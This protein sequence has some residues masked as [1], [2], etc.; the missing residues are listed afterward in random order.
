[1]ARMMRVRR[2]WWEL[3]IVVTYRFVSGRPLDGERRTD[4]TW[5]WA[6]TK[7]TRSGVERFSAWSALPGW[8]RQ[9][10][11]LVFV[12]PPIAAGV[13]WVARL[14]HLPAWVTL[15]ARGA[16]LVVLA[17]ALAVVGLAAWRAVGRLLEWRHRREWVLPLHKALIKP[18]GLGVR[19]RPESYLTVP[20]DFRSNP[21]A[22]IRVELPDT[23]ASEPGV[24]A[25]LAEVITS[26]LPL[27]S[28]DVM[29]RVAGK[30][31]HVIVRQAPAPP[32][33]VDYATAIPHMRTAPDSAPFLGLGIRSKPIAV[34]L[35]AESPHVLISASSG[36]GKSVLARLIMCQV[37]ANGGRV[38]VLDVKRVSHAWA[39]G[40][41]GVAYCRSPEEIHAAL[42][43]V[44]AEGDRRYDL[45]DAEGE[46]ACDRLPRILVVA[47]EMNATI[48]R[49]NRYWGKIR[50]AD[51]P[52]ISPAVEALGDILFMGRQAR[53]H[54][55]A[56]AQMMT[57]RAL[58]GPEARENFAT[59][60][61]ARYTINAWKMLAPEVW[62]AP[63]SSRHAGRVQVVLGGE[64]RATQVAFL[65]ADDARSYVVEAQS[66]MPPEALPQ[67]P[68][69]AAVLG[70]ERPSVPSAP[71]A[72]AVAAESRLRLVATPEPVTPSLGL[73]LPAPPAEPELV[74]L[75]MACE[76]DGVLGGAVPPVTLESARSA[77]KRDPEFPNPITRRGQEMVY[78]AAELAAWARNR[79]RAGVEL[80]RVHRG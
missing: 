41:P 7:S 15:A 21:D 27:E 36:G 5:R 22:L 58:G 70:G 46:D 45:I 1:M 17:A 55:L 63:K 16:V 77:R 10:V 59:R 48:A 9:A 64:A 4:A 62:P 25:S 18:L 14:L 72:P 53:E 13:A 33:K 11:R 24:R 6:G 37:L 47:E 40:L 78:D 12:V 43:A 29:W 42:V 60:I 68:T 66:A 39:R 19:T 57:A 23:F 51:D 79:P 74:G 30:N 31:P 26:K 65:T 67:G 56:I 3:V 71:G 2:P 32:A 73:D 38:I 35:D 50:T 75:A 8:K 28:P 34:D 80:P 52:K 49:L 20:R 61:L 69:V 44:A 76:P 54:V